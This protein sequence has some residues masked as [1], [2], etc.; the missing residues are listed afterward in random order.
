[1]DPSETSYKATRQADETVRLS[2]MDM[3]SRVTTLIATDDINIRVSRELRSVK[4][5]KTKDEYLYAMKEDL[6]E[7]FN[8]L[9][10]LEISADNFFEQLD[11]GIVL[12]CHAQLTRNYIM[13]QLSPSGENCSESKSTNA[14]Q[15]LQSDQT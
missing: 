7:W 2:N 9:Y 14:N 4:P 13:G 5:Y 11:T 8:S 3:I 1:M 6:S 15:Q 10:G 12:C